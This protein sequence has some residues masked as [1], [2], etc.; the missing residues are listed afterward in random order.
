MRERASACEKKG[1]KWGREREESVAEKEGATRERG[2]RKDEN[3]ARGI[4]YLT[5]L[6][7]ATPHRLLRS[8]IDRPR[9]VAPAWHDPLFVRPPRPP[10][11]ADAAV[12]P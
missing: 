1:E 6:S 9:S 5:H 12:C 10:S 3:E 2:N 8:S 11:C 7:D 4:V